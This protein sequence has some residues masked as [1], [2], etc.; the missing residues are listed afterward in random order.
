MQL[1][2]QCHL[3]LYMPRLQYSNHNKLV[4]RPTW[5]NTSF[6]AYHLVRPAQLHHCY[7]SVAVMKVTG[8]AQ[9][10]ERLAKSVVSP[11]HWF[12]W[13]LTDFATPTPHLSIGTVCLQKSCC[14]IRNIVL[15]DTSRHS[16]LTT[17]T[18]PSHWYVTNASLAF[19]GHIW[20][21]INVTIIFYIFYFIVVVVIVISIN[22]Q[23]TNF[24]LFDVALYLTLHYITW[25]RI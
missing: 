19:S 9:E 15:K 7:E 22:G 20:R 11:D 16:C 2:F 17:V 21:S 25:N 1:T 14:A 5:R 24:I 6:N 13:P 8:A 10:N 23:W 18:R 4:F 12:L 3:L